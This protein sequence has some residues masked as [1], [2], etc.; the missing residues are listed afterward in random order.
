MLDP[1]HSHREV[2]NTESFCLSCHEM[3]ANV[4]KE[5][6]RTAHFSNR[7][8]VRDSCPD[9]HVPHDW[10][11]TIA[12]KMQAS[13]EVWGHLFG[14]I[15]TRQKSLDLRLELAKHEWA[16]LRPSPGKRC[17]TSTGLPPVWRTF[18]SLTPRPFRTPRD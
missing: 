12:R 1:V 18:P 2:T 7:S 17:G 6:G 15:H 11:D 13:K 14:T 5:L 10:T 9:C 16:E 4:F 3:E 8:G